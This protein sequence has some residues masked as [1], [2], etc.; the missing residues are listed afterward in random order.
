MYKKN[1]KN[2]YHLK[3]IIIIVILLLLSLLLLLILLLFHHSYS[4]FDNCSCCEIL[5]VSG[6]I[7]T[8]Q[9]MLSDNINSPNKLN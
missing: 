3:F 8:Y 9:H 1:I 5:Y 4:Y 7:K 6:Y 2:F